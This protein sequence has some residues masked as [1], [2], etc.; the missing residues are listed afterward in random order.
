[1]TMQWSRLLSA[2]RL[3]HQ[4]A[5]PVTPA[6]NP[7]QKDWDRVVF[8]SAFRRLQDKTQVHSLP[9]SDYVR[10]RLTHS[11]EVSSVGRSLGAQVGQVV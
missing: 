4:G 9:E 8:C 1:M 2:Q 6:R 10:N 7:F 11:L 3:G 5:E